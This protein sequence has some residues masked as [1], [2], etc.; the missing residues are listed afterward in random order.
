ML[1]KKLLVI[2]A[3]LVAIYVG[4]SFFFQP[5]I[6]NKFPLMNEEEPLYEETYEFPQN[7]NGFSLEETNFNILS[8]KTKTNVWCA[9][10]KNFMA[11]H[12]YALSYKNS[13]KV[14]IVDVY[15]PQNKNEAI[16]CFE[17]NSEYFS[18]LEEI[19]YEKIDL[20]RG[21]AFFVTGIFFSGHIN[22]MIFMDENSNYVVFG[23]KI[24]D[25]QEEFKKARKKPQKHRHRPRGRGLR[26]GR[27]A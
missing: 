22:N 18:G 21:D 17:F 14:L 13:D 11:T 23:R 12:H 3:V 9:S 25:S 26:Y 16:S 24:G 15:V 8:E 19:D 5:E 10:G 2:L 4:I 1:Y 27:A 6:S 7:I 20:G